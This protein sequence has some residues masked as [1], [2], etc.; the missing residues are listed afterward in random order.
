VLALCAEVQDT[1]GGYFSAYAGGDL[2]PSGLVKGWAIEQA[3]ELLRAAGSAS[4]CVNGGGDVQCAGEFAPGQPWRIGVAHPLEPD[5]LAAVVVG[6]DLAVATSGVAE[7][8][9]H[10]V[11]P[12]TG[13]PPDGLACVT[14]VGPRLTFADAYATAA[15]AMG[16]AAQSWIEQLPD[17]WGFGIDADGAAWRTGGFGTVDPAQSAA[18]GRKVDM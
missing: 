4:H 12:H 9:R 16:A 18:S 1:T 11:D 15:F 5:K 3:S 14:V 6:N 7:R 10:L 8:G 2:D 13:R 17:H